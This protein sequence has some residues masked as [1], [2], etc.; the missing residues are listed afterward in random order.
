[1]DV[2]CSSGCRQYTSGRRV[3][4]G[5]SPTK[6]STEGE[7]TTALHLLSLVDAA[8]SFMYVCAQVSS[9]RL[10]LLYAGSLKVL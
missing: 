1:M 8:T 4:S 2:A 3:L 9:S 6:L 10:L 5:P 7:S